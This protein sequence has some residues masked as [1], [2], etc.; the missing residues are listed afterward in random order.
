MSQSQGHNS[1]YTMLI[2]QNDS[3][4]PNSA[5]RNSS[6]DP[7]DG[8]RQKTAGDPVMLCLRCGH[9][10]HPSTDG[11]QNVRVRVVE[12]NSIWN[13]MI[14]HIKEI[15]PCGGRNIRVAFPR[16]KT[17]TFGDLFHQSGLVEA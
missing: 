13:G 14:G 3:Q 5:C 2:R 16:S 9:S 17:D 4:C 15:L 12:P 10:W 11:M 6:R 7:N 8:I 1:K